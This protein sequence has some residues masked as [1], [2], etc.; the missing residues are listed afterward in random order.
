[1]RS[2]NRANLRGRLAGAVGALPFIRHGGYFQVDIDAVQ[3]RTADP[4]MDYQ[5]LRDTD[6]AIQF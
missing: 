3:Q 1:M 2:T 4:G 6:G 5:Q